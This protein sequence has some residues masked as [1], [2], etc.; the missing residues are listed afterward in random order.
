MPSTHRCSYEVGSCLGEF[1]VAIINAYF[2][3]SLQKNLSCGC[4]RYHFEGAIRP[5]GALRP[6]II[7]P[8][9]VTLTSLH[10]C[11]LPPS[12]SLLQR[13][14]PHREAYQSGPI[15]QWTVL[16]VCRRRSPTLPA[17]A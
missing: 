5:V 6:I 13:R 1:G 15:S 8:L 10:P 7:Y 14:P 17:S 3:R 9:P 12:L 11:P 4:G 2:R 16:P